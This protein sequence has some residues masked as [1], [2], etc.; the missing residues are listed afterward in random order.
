MPDFELETGLGGIVCGIDEVGR[1]PWAGPVVAAAVILDPASLP[2]DVLAAI[3]D[4]KKVPPARRPALAAAIRTHAR[5]GVG[6]AST[7]EIDRDNVL[8]ATFAAMA[9]AFARLPVA[10][11]AVLVDGDRAPP[12]GCRVVTVVGGDARSLSIA[13]ASIV[14]KVLRDAMMAK[15][16]LRHPGYGWETNVGYGT[17]GHREGI[18][19]FGV[20]RHHRHSFAPVSQM[21]SPETRPNR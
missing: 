4:S 3:D 21:L 18:V 8:R 12:L 14:A 2:A 13:A 7:R 17:P 5:V 6:A 1:G 11:D 9:R 15:L 10:P 20:T 19:R 16:A